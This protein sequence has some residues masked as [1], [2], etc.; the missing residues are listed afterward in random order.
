MLPDEK[1]REI[2]PTLATHC[3]KYLRPHTFQMRGSW[4]PG[5]EQ[6]VDHR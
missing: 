4:R 5:G 3:F 2:L 1:A 6:S